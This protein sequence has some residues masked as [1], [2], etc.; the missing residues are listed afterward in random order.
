MDR[1]VYIHGFNSGAESRSGR[2]L[3][4]LLQQP[5]IRPQ[6]DYSLPFAQ[7]LDDM[8]RQIS[9]QVSP[10]DRVCLMGSSL[11]GFYALHL[12]GPAICHVVAWNPVIYPAVQ[13][14]PFT[15]RNSRFT[16]GGEWE[17]TRR[18]LLSYAGA[19][20]PRPWHNSVWQEEHDRDG[21]SGGRTAAQCRGA[22]PPPRDIFLG[23]HDELLSSPLARAYWQGAATLHDIDAGHS[24]AD[25]SHA[26]DVLKRGSVPCLEGWRPGGA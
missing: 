10:N 9:R 11:G 23:T 22:A 21:G 13:L 4:Q 7:C 3:E 6:C 18:A 2:L 14:E 25:Y 5:V 26:A 12:R 15:G 1:F 16:D 24:I 8:R 17:F 19:P 20:D